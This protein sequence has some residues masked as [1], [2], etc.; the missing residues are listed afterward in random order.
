MQ[1]AVN[2]NYGEESYF[3]GGLLSLIGI[4]ILGFLITLF[5]LGICLPWAICKSY[6]WR[7]E[8][9]VINGQRL[10]FNGTAMGLFGNW[11]KW[12]VL[13]LVTLGIYSFWVGIALEKWRV[14]HTSF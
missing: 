6:K 5:T 7:I 10:K 2:L 3:D 12:W 11:I 13:C 9:T 14:K 4:N 8:H 1:T